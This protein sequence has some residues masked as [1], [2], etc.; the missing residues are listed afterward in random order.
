MTTDLRQDEGKSPIEELMEIVAQRRELERREAAV[1]RK[2]HNSGMSWAGIAFALGV[3]R[4][5]AHRKY[6]RK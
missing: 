4:Q 2:A 3:S 1:V 6:G 5:A